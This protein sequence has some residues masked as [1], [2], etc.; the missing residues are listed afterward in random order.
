MQWS[1]RK[2]Q[3]IYLRAFMKLTPRE[4][5]FVEND[6]RTAN[7]TDFIRFTTGIVIRVIAQTW[8]QV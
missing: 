4:D 1:K 3:E 8:Q 2:Q 5:S 6:L 7:S